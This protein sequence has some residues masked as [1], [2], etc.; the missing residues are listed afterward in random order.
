VP[1]TDEKKPVGKPQRNR[2]S[3]KR[4]RKAEQNRGP[5][6]D[7]KVDPLQAAKQQIDAL[8]AS[9]E[10]PP[11]EARDADE[12]IAATLAPAEV[13]ATDAPATDAQDVEEIV[14][15]VISAEALPIEA[16]DLDEP[17]VATVTPVEALPI[18]APDLEEPVVAVATVIPT[19]ALSIEAPDLEEPVVAAVTLAEAL[20]VGTAVS[21]VNVPVSL[22]TIANAYGDYTRKSFEQTKSYFDRLTGVRSF[23]KAVEVQTEFAQQA[24]ETFV[25]EARRIRELQ[26][27]LAMQPFKRLEGLVA[28]M[29]EFAR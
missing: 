3:D 20:P 1:E 18:E 26:N 6:P 7:Q 12:Q 24:Y 2:K 14:A 13:P 28:R 16:A 11:I 5:K 15:A 23:D 8:I 9:T 27:E 21:T 19:E 17:V 22:Q 10:A 29:T 25:A 4:S